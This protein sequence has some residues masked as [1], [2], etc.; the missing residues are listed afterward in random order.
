MVRRVAPGATLKRD[1]DASQDEEPR[2]DSEESQPLVDAKNQE[3][4]KLLEELLRAARAIRN[5]AARFRDEITSLEQ[6]HHPSTVDEE[7]YEPFN[8]FLNAYLPLRDLYVEFGKK[9]DELD[10]FIEETSMCASND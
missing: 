8:V 10:R 2:S 6:N 1:R 3:L 4:F 5:G 7:L 9:N